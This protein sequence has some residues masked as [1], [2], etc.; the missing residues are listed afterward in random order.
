MAE[1]EELRLTVNL[2][3]NS[4][5]G[6]TKIRTELVSLTQTAGQMAASVV[7]ASQSVVQLGSSVQAAT[8]KIQAVSNEMRAMQRHAADTG[9]AVGQMGYAAQQGLAGLPQM[10]I[11]LWDASAG[12]RGL[13][14]SLKAVAP[15]AQ[16]S[17]MAL[18]GVAVGVAAVGIAVVAYGISVFKFAKEMDQL[19]KTARALG[20]SFAELR[21]AQEQ[22]KAFGSTAD[23]V[24]R[25]FQGIQDAQLDLYKNNS[26]LRQKLLGQGVDANWVNQ[27]AAADPGKARSMIAQYGKAL[28][29]Q[30][31]EAGVG[32]SVAAAIRNQF[33]GEFGQKPE[34]MELALK[35]VDPARAAEM[36]RVEELSRNVSKV[37][38]EI[39][40][41]LQGIT[42][43]A[44][45]AGLPILLGT[46][47]V[48]DGLFS[49][50]G[51][52]VTFIDEQLGKLG[53]NLV[54][55]L[56][57]IPG[58][59]PVITMVEGLYK[60]GGGGVPAEGEPSSG[61]IPLT[62]PRAQR[63]SYEGAN[64]NANPLLQRA[65]FTT[66]E[67]IDETGRNTS[68]VERLT[69][70][71]EK[72]NSFFDRAGGSGR[73]GGG[74]GGITNASLTTGGAATG[75]GGAAAGGGGSGGF[76]S[77]GGYSVL[78]NDNDSGGGPNARPAET[79]APAAA[80]PAPAGGGGGGRSQMSPADANAIMTGGN[81]GSMGTV[82]QK[83]TAGGGGG[84][85]SVPVDDSMKGR[86]AGLQSL[87]G[88]VQGAGMT[89]TSGYRDPGHSLSR[90][91]R[92]SKHTQGLAFDTRARTAEQAD[93]AMAKQREL[94][95]SRGM[96]EGRDYSFIDEVRKPS[97][98]ATGPH[99]HTQLTPEGMRRYQQS[100]AAEQ[101]KVAG[102]ATTPA[103]VGGYPSSWYGR[104]AGGDTSLTASLGSQPVDGGRGLARADGSESPALRGATSGDRIPL[105]RDALDRQALSDAMKVRA[106]GSVKVDV[107]GSSSK[108]AAANGN[109]FVDTPL[110]RSTAGQ[111][112]NYGPN[113]A[114][115][116]KQYMASR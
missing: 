97:G 88:D 9:R 56:K 65:S 20:M 57:W 83:M 55:V 99:V 60:L 58:L 78:P 110:Q 87:M 104:G 53:T 27:L 47:K 26:Q 93:T 62:M 105:Q 12:V 68:Q 109:L 111:L 51:A 91:N 15:A 52:T 54:A 40:L 76:K 85:A 114:E 14:E 22:A 103:K 107:G 39:S 6:L 50:I 35:P 79:A 37:W 13:G 23:S 46:L 102:V 70:Q 80:L 81:V 30:A 33:Y 45:S 34:D 5:T 116:A 1:F 89:T 11:G 86:L 71:L 92:G 75:G 64:D 43:A 90:A 38:G 41:K 24:I 19:G 29:R 4:S 8:P 100:K 95:S 21:N 96:V 36:R 113:A 115:T 25:S 94:F 48:A 67:L 3:D 32:K 72:L 74:Q 28:E 101:S 63:S 2:V 10:A 108:A 49:G 84:G 7:Q 17:I 73:G 77:G 31:V 18:A 59:G 106:D 82:P 98:H 16:S 66:D 112:T 69:S 42:F 44:L 61:G